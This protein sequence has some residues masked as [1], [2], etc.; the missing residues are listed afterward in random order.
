MS[1]FTSRFSGHQTFPL[2]YGWLYK[3]YKNVD[4]SLSN[5]SP[6]EI[7]HASSDELMIRWGVGKNMVDAIKYWVRQVGLDARTKDLGF[8]KVLLT[9]RYLEEID[10]IWLLHW[11]LCSNHREL[12][13]YRIFFNYFNGVKFDRKSFLDFII[14]LFDKKN[15]L[16]DTKAKLSLSLPNEASLKK[17]IGV[18]FL[19]YVAGSSN[20]VTEDSFASPLSELG[21][22]KSIDKNTYLC[23]LEERNSLSDMVF[24]FAML[25]FLASQQSFLNGN[26]TMAF[27]IFISLPG[28]PARIF[29]MSRSEVE[30]RLDVVSKI[31]KGKIGWTDTQGLRQIQIFDTSILSEQNQIDALSNVYKRR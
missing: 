27:D 18:F 20:C 14:D 3:F 15:F 21:L 16:S 8:Y 2:R 1:S 30:R 9:D 26:M 24:N 11:F 23:E 17:D 28:S 19:C 22:I 10:S 29:R 5:L 25:S 7:G 4:G 12:T 13:S 6:D 31:N